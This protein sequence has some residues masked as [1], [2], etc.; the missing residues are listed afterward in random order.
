[1]SEV[2]NRSVWKID[3]E[4]Q[5]NKEQKFSYFWECLLKKFTE[6]GKNP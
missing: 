2:S 3:N 6:N 5:G 4:D 1:M